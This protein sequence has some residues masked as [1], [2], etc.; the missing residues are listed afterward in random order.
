MSKFRK[1]FGIT[2]VVVLAFMAIGATVVLASPVEQGSEEETATE[3]D[4]PPIERGL[5]AQ[6]FDRESV[7]AIIAD[8]LGISVEELEAAKEEG[9]RMQ[10]L[11]EEQG[12]AI[13]DIQAAVEAYKAEAVQDALDAE[14]ITE[15]QAEWL[16][17]HDGRPTRHQV[18]R[19]IRN[20]IRNIIDPD[21]MKETAADALGLSVEEFAEAREGGMTMQ[22]LAEEQGVEIE[23]VWEAMRATFEVLVE[24]AVDDGTITRFQADRILEHDGCSEGFFNG[25]DGVGNEFASP[26]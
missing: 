19:G 12:V 18:R 21:M 6:I 11:A 8:T 1:I 10:Q 17:S 22:E 25:R 5:L 9:I 15:A 2:V 4:Q 26:G 14:L 23:V 7:Q 16:L 24:Q 13:E 3:P 20:L